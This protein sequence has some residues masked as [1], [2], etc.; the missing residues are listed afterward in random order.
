MVHVIAPT[1]EAVKMLPTKDAASLS[2]CVGF[3][4]GKPRPLTQWQRAW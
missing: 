3:L 1:K 2:Y 4:E